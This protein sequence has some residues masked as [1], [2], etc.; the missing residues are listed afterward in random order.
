MKK[1]L[2]LL[3][4][5]TSPSVFAASAMLSGIGRVLSEPD[6]VELSIQVQSKCYST[7]KDARQANDDAARKIVDFLNKKIQG[8]ES[9]YNKV[10]TLGGYTSPFQVYHRNK[11]LCENTFQKHNNITLR[12]QRVQDFE[13]LYDEIQKEVYSHFTMQPRGMIESSVTFVTMSQPSPRV[14]MERRQELE[15]K[16]LTMALNDA[17]GKLTALFH[18]KPIEN[19]KITEV[20]E[21]AMASPP[22]VH[23]S[24]RSGGAEMM[25]MK[26]D[27]AP[28]PV[29]FDEQWIHKQVY[30]RFSFEDVTIP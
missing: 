20:S 10:I 2:A 17:K 24:P 27:A 16:A 8:S 6:Y 3:L 22:P 15:Q 14:S 29:Q 13:Q 5:V 23:Y 26:A 30:I 18:E 9:Y 4:M 25:A 19:L 21:T 1:Y 7:P 11:I 12:T 28:A